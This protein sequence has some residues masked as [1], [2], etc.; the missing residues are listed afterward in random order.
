MPRPSK[1]AQGSG[2]EPVIRDLDHLAM[3]VAD[4][5]ATLAFYND[6]LGVAVVEFG[7]GRKALAIGSMKINLHPPGAPFEPKA[8]KPTPGSLDLCLLTDRP[9][10][11]VA[12][13][14]RDRGIEVIEG[15]VQRTGTNAPL[16]SIYCRDPDGNLLE[17]A[18]EIVAE[19][20]LT[21]ERL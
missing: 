5:D 14:L 9:V 19:E 10:D 7:G 16:W 12:A 13:G 18:Q 15:P 17:I 21:G 20:R 4:L 1:I 6:I 2:A 11:E 8:L 3:T